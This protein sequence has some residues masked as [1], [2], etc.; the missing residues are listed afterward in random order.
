MPRSL[1][2]AESKVGGEDA[3]K[4]IV[5]AEHAEDAGHSSGYEGNVVDDERSRLGQTSDESKNES[6][7]CVEYSY[8]NRMIEHHLLYLRLLLK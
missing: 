8:S 7:D 5:D 1:T 2:N 4:P 6:S 3:V